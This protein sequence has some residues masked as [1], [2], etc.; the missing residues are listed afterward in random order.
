MEPQTA[1]EPAGSAADVIKQRL[2]QY[3][4]AEYEFA[5][6]GDALY[7]RHLAFD[8]AVGA[9]V[10]DPR[11]RFEAFARAVRDVLSQRWLKTRETY[12]RQDPKRVYYL[13]MEFLIGRMMNNNIL[14]L[15]V[16]PVMQQAMKEHGLDWHHLAELEPDAGLGNGGLGRLAA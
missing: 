4:C 8:N 6:S 16:E 7:E 13:S 14:N 9:A 1:T 11:E 5:G 3:G 2:S 12:T 10:L 15:L